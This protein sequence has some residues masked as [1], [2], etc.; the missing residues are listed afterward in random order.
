MTLVGS[1]PATVEAGTPF[2]LT[3]NIMDKDGVHL[4]TGSDS[5][6]FGEIHVAVENDTMLIYDRINREDILFQ[7]M[8]KYT[9]L[10]G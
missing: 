9:S 4:T 10:V 8:V 7:E 1:L 2:S 6:L 3:F 5:V